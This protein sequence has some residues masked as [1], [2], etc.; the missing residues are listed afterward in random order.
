MTTILIVKAIHYMETSASN[1]KKDIFIV[2][3]INFVLSILKVFKIAES[4]Q[5]KKLAFLV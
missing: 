3:P 1:V 4:I 5:M 2:L